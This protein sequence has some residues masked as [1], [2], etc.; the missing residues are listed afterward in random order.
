MKL[1]GN[2]NK[3]QH[4]YTGENYHFH[5]KNFWGVCWSSFGTDIV[6]TNLD[7]IPMCHGGLC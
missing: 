3:K 4:I 1:T 7:Q 5:T 6:E 2:K